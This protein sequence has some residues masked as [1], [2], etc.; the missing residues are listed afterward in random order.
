[1]ARLRTAP[2]LPAVLAVV[3]SGCASVPEENRSEADPW[4]SVNR[5]IFG[6][7][8]AVDKVTTKPL[9]KGYEK[10][11]PQPVRKS[12][13]NF[14]RNLRTPIHRAHCTEAIEQAAKLPDD[15]PFLCHLGNH[16]DSQLLIRYVQFRTPWGHVSR[17]IKP[18][19]CFIH[20]FEDFDSAAV[21]LRVHLV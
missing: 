6:F 13:T 18:L 14:F 17:Q 10:V 4:E 5:P 3:L 15:R 2:V 11:V 1:M 21:L 19:K 8:R 20:D 9:A 7:N 12:V 16:A